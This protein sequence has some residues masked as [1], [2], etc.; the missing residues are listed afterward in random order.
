MP[1]NMYYA[2][3]YSEKE[4]I[5]ILRD[6]AAL[7]ELIRNH[8]QRNIGEY[9][10]AHEDIML[11]SLEH[12]VL[13]RTNDPR[14]KR[15]QEYKTFINVILSLIDDDYSEAATNAFINN[16]NLVQDLKP[17]MRQDDYHHILESIRLANTQAERITKK[18]AKKLKVSLED[19]DFISDYHARLKDFNNFEYEIL[20][21]YLFGPYLT[22]K[23][24]MTIASPEISA[25]L[26]YL[27][28]VYNTGGQ[29]YGFDYSSVRCVLSN[30]DIDGKRI[31]TTAFAYG[32]NV[33][34]L[35]REVFE[36]TD[37]QSTE[38]NKKIF[39][40]KIIDLPSLLVIAFHELTHN[41]QTYKGRVGV[42]DNQGLNR[43]IE[44]LEQ[45]YLNDYN[46]NHDNCW[47]EINATAEAF[48]QTRM[49]VERFYSGPNKKQLIE[50]CMRNFRGTI[51]REAFA[52]KKD[53]KRQ[54]TPL[55]D[56]DCLNT[57]EIIFN[58]PEE[59][60]N[61]PL[62]RNF[63]NEQG[64]LDFTRY[65]FIPELPLLTFGRGCLLTFLHEIKPFELHNYL[66]AYPRSVQ[67]VG[68]FI[69]NINRLFYISIR[70]IRNMDFYKE[71]KLSGD[72]HSNDSNTHFE[73][74]HYD[75][76]LNT[77]SDFYKSIRFLN[78][79]KTL[80]QY[81]ALYSKIDETV[82][83]IQESIKDIVSETNISLEAKQSIL[84]FD[85]RNAQS[86]YIK[87]VI[88]GELM[89]VVRSRPFDKEVEFMRPEDQERIYKAKLVEARRK[90][91]LPL[92]ILYKNRINN[93]EAS[94]NKQ[95]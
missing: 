24:N 15:S 66:C 84:E 19:L 89:K 76:L 14:F 94:I 22:S 18:M 63:Y 13:S 69:D 57:H 55:M 20:I 9:Y 3:L 16:C 64:R 67:E 88:D 35:D 4:Y 73:D 34:Y 80:P 87:H 42:L 54:K 53:A 17:Y 1:Y 85:K 7:T 38:S 43:Q 82:H 77:L 81:Y 45:M 28:S 40:S 31:G 25:I 27:P 70:D 29:F 71:K 93:L 23:S 65:I 51:T 95:V 62:L 59:L 83:S 60:N 50:D 56:Y 26:A 72:F 36:N 10:K 30:G 79:L 44:D 90:H 52:E 74:I 5:D 33:S 61:F 48:I 91:N 41:F 58:H 11:E 21:R 46:R 75:M 86:P 6:Y 47:T 12:Y 78:S 8:A 37:F 49:F 2:G 39:Q 68:N 92:V 32:E